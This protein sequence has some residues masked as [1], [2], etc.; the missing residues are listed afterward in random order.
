MMNPLNLAVRAIL[1]LFLLAATAKWGWELSATWTKYLWAIGIPLGLA[2][3]WGVFAVP[4]DPS[5]S[6][7]T[8]VRTPGWIRLILELSMFGFGTWCLY[9]L[10]YSNVGFAL[11]FGVAGHYLFSYK[12]VQ[13]LF[14][15]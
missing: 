7:K 13:W 1:E 8:V 2:V 10:G 14:Q 6:G 4:D 12:R 9:H 5:R 15:H 11:G 3:V